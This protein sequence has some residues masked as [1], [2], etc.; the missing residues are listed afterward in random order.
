[1]PDV[2]T[3]LN[4]FTESV[5]REMTRISNKYNAINL[6]QGFPDFDPPVELIHAAKRALAGDHH[7]YA[8]TWGAPRFREAL[9]RKQR[10]WMGLDLDPDAHVVVTCG[11]TEAMMVAMMT[12]C[13]PGDRVIILSLIRVSGERHLKQASRPWYYATP[14]IPQ[15]R[16]SHERRWRPL[17]LWRRSSMHSSSPTKYMNILFTHPM[18]ISILPRCRRCLSGPFLAAL[19]QK[20]IPSPDGVWGM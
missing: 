20:R 3:R 6:S 11:S 15:G 16:Y 19:F 18:N 13:N 2:A 1:M 7:Q 10:T 5:I 9:A 17:P 12:A 14:P 8:I 4:T